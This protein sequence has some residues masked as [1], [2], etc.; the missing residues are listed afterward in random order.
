MRREFTL[1]LYDWVDPDVCTRGD[2][3]GPDTPIP[4]MGS[5]IPPHTMCLACA[6]RRQGYGNRRTSGWWKAE[7]KPHMDW[8]VMDDPLDDSAATSTPEQQAAIMDWWRNR[9]ET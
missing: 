5:P 6:R 2:C 4:P 3:T 1:Q 8:I 9:H 7:P